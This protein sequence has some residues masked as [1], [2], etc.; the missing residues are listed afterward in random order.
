[1]EHAIVWP[2]PIGYYFTGRPPSIC[3][4]DKIERAAQAKTFPIDFVYKLPVAKGGAGC[5]SVVRL[6]STVRMTYLQAAVPFEIC[7]GVFLAWR[8]LPE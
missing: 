4:A 5:Q 2:R 6:H 1:M 3:Q 7:T 8:P